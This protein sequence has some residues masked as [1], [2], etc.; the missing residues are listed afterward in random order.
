MPAWAKRGGRVFAGALSAAAPASRAVARLNTLVSSAPLLDRN[1]QWVTGGRLLHRD[2]LYGPRLRA[3]LTSVRPQDAFAPGDGGVEAR[4]MRL[5]QRRWLPDDVLAKADRA[6]MQAS[7]ELRTP[8]L[9]RE[10]AEFAASVPA[11][12]HVRGSG[13]FLLREVLKSVLPDADHARPKV[14]FRTPTAEWL[15][16]PLAEAAASQFGASAVYT[17]GWF[18]PAE[19]ERLFREHLTGRRDLSSVL[20]PIFVL[21]TWLDARRSV[22]AR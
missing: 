9:S 15:R 8:Y 21:G 1:T 13:K 19:V 11:A 18:A 2:L 10:V 16:G 4:F 3:M 22:E 20:W 7:L 12:V 14:A 17:D 6:T 5:D